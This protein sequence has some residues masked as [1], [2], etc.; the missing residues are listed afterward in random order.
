MTGGSDRTVMLWNPARFDPVFPPPYL[1]YDS[2]GD[3][4][5][6][7]LLPRAL[8]IQIY[9]DGITHP[10]SAVATDEQSTTLALSSDKTLVVTDIVTQRVKRRLQGHLGRINAIAISQGCETFLT[11]S[12]D[13]TVRIWDGRSRSHEPI[14]ILK[15]ARDSVTDVHV[16]QKDGTAI[17]RTS[18]VD[19]VIR[20][21][22]LRKGV[23]R[24][25]DCH[26]AI[27]AMSPTKDGENIA[28]NCLDGRIRLI[29][30]ESGQ[31]LNT[32]EKG[33]IAGQYGLECCI[34]ADDTTIVTGSED[35]RAVLY[36]LVRATVVQALLGH[37]R[38]TCSVAA[39]PD[40]EYSDAIITASYD[41]HN[42]VWAHD[43]NFISW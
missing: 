4:T 34:T 1:D 19:G 32:Y 42:V 39:H 36:D 43:K 40:R 33:H 13:A 21:Y 24:C 25:D 8:P 20:S 27:T 3:T 29:D 28:V 12:Y 2:H 23:T 30:V 26:T 35:G 6:L 17:I 7:E 14:Q 15:D 10:V 37:T 11:A 9:K 22:D 5:P 41:G 38:P 18:S 31:L 16:D